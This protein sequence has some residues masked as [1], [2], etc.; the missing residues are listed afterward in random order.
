MSKVS[1][2]CASYNSACYLSTTI[3]SI[4]NQYY[5]D[6]ELIIID[7]CSVDNTYEIAS[8]FADTDSRIRILSNNKNKGPAKTRNKGIREAKGK[9][10]TFIDSDDLW[11]KDFIS[12]SIS[13][14]QENNYSFC[15][16]SYYR[17]DEG[18]D[19]L[20]TPFIVPKKVSYN[21][22]LKTCPISCLTAFIDIGKI[23]K[24]YMPD[25]KQRQDY[26]LWLNIL[27]DVDFA[28]GIKK[29]LATY[30]IRKGSVSRNKFEAMKYV[31]KLY[32]EEEGLNIV[33]SI[34]LIVIYSFNGLKKY[35]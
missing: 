25:L 29:K 11:E 24:Y 20:Y 4:I 28:Y 9:Y 21:D 5:K 23:G 27:K 33:R 15:F 14:L 12:K 18:L 13:F 32:R 34:Y 22:L 3:N 2:I 10:L 6:W 35:S 19:P 26:G 31:W 8:K 16:S 1:I 17:V 30:R 7:D